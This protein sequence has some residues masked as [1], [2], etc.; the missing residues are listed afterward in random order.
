MASVSAPALAVALSADAAHEAVALLQRYT[1]EVSRALEEVLGAGATGT[2]DVGL[3]IAIHARP[4]LSPAE[5]GKL[6]GS[7]R[8]TV[9]RGLARLV[10]GGLVERRTSA[11]DRRR[12]ELV[13][14]RRGR[15]SI[16]RMNDVL[17]AYYR[18]GE[19]LAKEAMHLVGRQSHR[20]TEDG[21]IS[22]LE[23]ASRLGRA[24]ENARAAVDRAGH[25]FGLEGSIDRYAVVVVALGETRPSQLAHELLL[26]PTG[27][28]SLLDR[29]G[30]RG[31]VERIPGAIDADRRAVVVRAT[32]RGRDAAAAIVTAY[33]PHLDSI[34]DAV[35]MTMGRD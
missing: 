7:P 6:V 13:L 10:G 26:T 21:E 32:Q 35:E 4:R 29:L 12:T 23:V 16:D 34:A 14:T 30:A 25:Q 9:A 1:V 5:A 17:D 27:T 8:S 18:D 19:A 3:L 15:R 11:D 2:V 20:P 22:A 31:L 28:S 33:A 24:A